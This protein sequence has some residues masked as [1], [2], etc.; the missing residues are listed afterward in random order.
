MKVLKIPHL[1]CVLLI[2]FVF[3]LPSMTVFAETYDCAAG[4]HKYIVTVI[5]P[6]ADTDGE[7]R[8]VCELCGFHYEETL[9]ATLH[10]WGPWIT[11]SEPTCTEEGHRH[12]VCSKG[13]THTQEE[14]VKA[15]GHIYKE[16]VKE[17]TCLENG[18]KI[19]ICQ[20]CGDTYKETYKS[21][22][23]HD[24]KEEITTPATS[25]KE[26]LKTFTCTRCGD[27]YTEVIPMLTTHQH[28]YVKHIDV[29]PDCEAAGKA[30][31]TCKLCGDT[32]SETI[33]P[34]GHSYG[35]W[36]TDKKPNLTQEG[37]QYKVCAHNSA[38]IIEETIP[39]EFNFDVTP[40][41]VAVAS[42][43]LGFLFFFVFTLLSDFSLIRWDLKKRK[44]LAMRRKKG[45]I[46]E[47][48]KKKSRRVGTW[49]MTVIC[50]LLSL[51]S[52]VV[53]KG[54]SNILWIGLVIFIVI[55]SAGIILKLL[56]R[57]IIDSLEGFGGVYKPGHEKG[58]LISSG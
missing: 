49:I 24:Y 27:S 7:R 52:M 40:A 43:N 34:L 41:D 26:G 13:I 38:H 19:F 35:E 39:R 56:I 58:K 50:M 32:Y 8:H 29:E 15:L 44:E 6:T 14:A 42:T 30:T 54:N 53:L 5:E 11:D 28:Q 10:V 55:L 12:R 36:I 1:L 3:M 4:K 22:L 31:Y 25:T 33:P 51:G 16:T 23:G 46:P 48:K 45:I 21:A 20:R 57:R 47:T 2:I 17:P 18:L 9:F 37:H